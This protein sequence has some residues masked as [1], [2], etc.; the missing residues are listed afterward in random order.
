MLSEQVC[1][2]GYQAIVYHIGQPQGSE[3][4]SGNG[5]DKHNSSQ[6]FVPYGIRQGQMMFV[7][8]FAV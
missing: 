2:C 4:D 1:Y 8:H 3:A 7:Y 5:G 6:A